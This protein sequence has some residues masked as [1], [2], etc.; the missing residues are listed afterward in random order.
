MRLT[1]GVSGVIPYS[2]AGSGSLERPS[3]ATPHHGL[4]D[5]RVVGVFTAVNTELD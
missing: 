5:R 4:G 1:D 2:S 3:D